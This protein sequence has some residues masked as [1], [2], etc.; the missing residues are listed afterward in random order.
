MAVGTHM[1]TQTQH[2]AR[3][4]RQEDTDV[5]GLLMILLTREVTFVLIEPFKGCK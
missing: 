3:Q 2:L 1:H 5:T 4:N